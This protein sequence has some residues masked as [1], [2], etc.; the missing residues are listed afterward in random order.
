MQEVGAHIN[1]A[2]W[3]VKKSNTGLSGVFSGLRSCST[4]NQ[5]K[6]SIAVKTVGSNNCSKSKRRKLRRKNRQR[7]RTATVKS[8]EDTCARNLIQSPVASV[9]QPSPDS[10]SRCASI[11]VSVPGRVQSHLVFSQGVMAT[12]LRPDPDLNEIS[13]TGSTS[14]TFENQADTVTVDLSDAFADSPNVYYQELEDTP[15]VCAE[16][17]DGTAT[18]SLIKVSKSHIKPASSDTSD[19]DID[20]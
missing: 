1:E 14:S 8:E 7:L 5:L 12:F 9:A 19:D 13:L 10:V 18:W 3:D 16:C 15:G 17:D 20:I 2:C 11:T 4:V 6:P